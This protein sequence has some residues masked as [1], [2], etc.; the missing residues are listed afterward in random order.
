[1]KILMVP[2]WYVT[3]DKP[4]NGIFFREQAQALEA[5][6]H[7]VR[8]IY[9]DV[10]FRLGGLRRGLIKPDGDPATFIMRRRTFTPFSERGRRPMRAKMLGALYGEAT[11]EWGKPDVVQLESCRIGPETLKLCAKHD[12][13]LVYTEHYSGVLR[14]A[15][16]VLGGAFR[17]TLEGCGAAVAVSSCLRDKMTPIR[18]DAAVVP[19]PVD[20]VKFAMTRSP[21]TIKDFTFAAMGGLTQIKRYD[22]LI[23]AF[24]LA[25]SGLE[26]AKLV[27]AGDGPL[28][29]PL[30]ALSRKLGVADSVAFPGAVS[31]DKAPEFYNSV[32]CLVC[33]SD[34]ETFG[35]TLIEALACGRPLI[36]TSCGGP[37]DIVTPRN[38][39]LVAPDD[40]GALASAMRGLYGAFG[41]YDSDAITADCA[42]RFGAVTFAKRMTEIY[43][44][45]LENRNAARG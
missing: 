32:S 41:R 30:A 45:T 43:E 27:I 22:L 24:A 23:R 4:M 44:E 29:E 39:V 5:A 34:F 13:P 17:R 7:D 3:E 16:A 19:N 11:A 35:I 21:R 38:G 37:R 15:D 31:R 10:R 40:V 2:S 18:P 28:R 8:V 33:S 26:G 9:P 42:L 14:G 36:S 6:G 1:M 25:R 12:L 20:T